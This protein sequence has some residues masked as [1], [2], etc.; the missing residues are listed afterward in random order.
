MTSLAHRIVLTENCNASCKH[1]FNANVRNKNEMDADILIDFMRRNTE[2]LK[3]TS[4]KIMGG[5][6]TLHPRIIDII[7]EGLKHYFTVSLFTNGINIDRI[8]KRF[9]NRISYT[10]NGYTFDPKKDFEVLHFVITKND[11]EKVIDKMM[12]CIVSHSKSIFVYSPDTQV[13][14]FDEEEF[15]DYRKTW[16]E[17]TKIIVPELNK[18]KMRWQLDHNLPLCFFTK[19][20]NYELEKLSLPTKIFSSCKCVEIGLIDWNFDLYYCN[21]TRIKLGT[22]LNKSIP[23][24]NEMVQNSREK[25][26]DNIKLNKKCQHCELINKCGMG[27]YYNGGRHV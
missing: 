8:V 25:K 27:C 2:Y 9:G 23:E 5:E 7:Q 22:I 10:V 20:I 17:A 21:Q 15:N 4:L 19:E 3:Y 13:N 18:R 1:C 14:I 16:I 12:K 24:L 26:I 11:T 6:P